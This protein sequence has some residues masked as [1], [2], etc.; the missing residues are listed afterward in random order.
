M[1]G[2]KVTYE[3]DGLLISIYAPTEREAK[4]VICAALKDAGIT[5]I[6]VCQE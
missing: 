6:G 3:K 5:N 1:N 2:F 4:N